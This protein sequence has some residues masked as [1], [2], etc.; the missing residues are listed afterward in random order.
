MKFPGF[1]QTSSQQG[2]YALMDVVAALHWIKENAGAFGGDVNRI[3]ILGHRTGA[4][5]ANF[6]MIAPV[7]SGNKKLH[8]SF[9]S[10]QVK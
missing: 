3:T 10:C 4:V 2:N 9:H 6:L 1:L 8:S 7:A 5:I